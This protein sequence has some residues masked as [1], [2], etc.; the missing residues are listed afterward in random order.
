MFVLFVEIWE[1]KGEKEV[2]LRL[3]KYLLTKGGCSP[4]VYSISPPIQPL[5]LSLMKKLKSILVV[6]LLVVALVLVA[7]AGYR[8]FNLSC[9]EVKVVIADKNTH[10]MVTEQQASKLILRSSANPVGQKVRKFDRKG[11]EQALKQNP[12][13]KE[14]QSTAINGSCLTVTIATKTPLALVFPADAPPLILANNG[15]LLPDDSRCSNLLVINGN[16]GKCTPHAF[17]KKK[18][19]LHN[20]Y[21]VAKAIAANSSYAAQYPEIFVRQDGQIELYSILGGHA[22]LLGN[23]DHLSDKLANL[24]A[25]YSHG[26]LDAGTYTTLD[27]RFKDRIYAAH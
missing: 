21:A 22:I 5:F 14:I 27:L 20:A 6:F 15:Q 10:T 25:A 24:D 17:V 7:L 12:W 13:V 4:K 2:S 18:S 11:I 1:E 3:L 8:Y 23:A 19:A 16:V 9:T 26:L